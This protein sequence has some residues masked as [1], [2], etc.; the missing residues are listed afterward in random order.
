MNIA[1]CFVFTGSRKPKKIEELRIILIGKTGVGKSAAGNTILGREAFESELSP[2]SKTAECGK[3][4]GVVGGRN[5]AL[6]DTPGL[7]DTRCP[8]EEVQE[9]INTCLSMSAPGPHAFL[10]VLQLGRFT[11]EEKET[12]KLIQTTF[13]KDAAKHTMV[14]FTHGDRLKRQTIEEFVSKSEELQEMIRKCHGRYHVFNNEV[15]DP[16]QTTQLFVKIDKMT[17][18]NGGRHYTGKM[19]KRAEK[20]IRKEK[21]RFWKKSEAQE[22]QRIKEMETEVKREMGHLTRGSKKHVFDKD[23]CL[24]Q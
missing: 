3:A 9:R 8:Q 14:L 21:R 1:H 20:A 22:K 24:I 16:S 10:V 5:V 12:V 6:I 17:K 7:F 11:T 4:T 13:G 2:S 15:Q 23:K 18:D 19:F